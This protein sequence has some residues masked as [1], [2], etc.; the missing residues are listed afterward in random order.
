MQ[1]VSVIIC[2]T[3]TK[4]VLKLCLENLK[5]SYENL[6]VIVADTNS[7]DGSPEMVEAEFPW[8][9]LL[10]IPN[11]GLAYALN[12]GVEAA[13][14]EYF[15]YLGSDGFPEKGTI[16]GLVDYMEAHEDVGAA[17]VKL[18]L[19]SGEQ[20]MDAH[21]GFPTP[22]ASFTHFTGIEK[23]FPKSKIFAQYFKTY[24]DLNKE[25]EID[26]CITHF[27]FVSKKVQDKI[28]GWDEQTFFLYGEDI[29]FC[30]RIKE[31]GYKIMYLPQLKAQ[32]W[33]GVTIGTRKVSQDVATKALV[34]SF[35]GQDVDRASFKVMT[36]KF[37]TQAMEL[38]YR[39]HYLKKYPLLLNVFV[40]VTIKTLMYLRIFKQR[41]VNW[42][43]RV[44][45]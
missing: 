42:R 33:K 32:H 9:K 31:V 43:E 21:R 18:I 14:G 29:D 20:D 28:G 10:K 11:N 39:K 44:R 30:Y 25:H 36:Q 7:Y 45:V 35:K 41:F 15:L 34:F 16:K 3:N 12:R 4:D 13:S 27:L 8:V 23:I 38:F 6:E 37:S 40:I 19:R 2:N 5:D 22:W 24:E 17:T 26:A 1:K